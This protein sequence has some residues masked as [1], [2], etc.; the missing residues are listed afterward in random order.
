MLKF[1]EDDK[2]TQRSLKKKKII[3]I[4]GPKSFLGL[5]RVRSLWLEIN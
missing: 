1:P 4:I 2:F 3:Y 5:L